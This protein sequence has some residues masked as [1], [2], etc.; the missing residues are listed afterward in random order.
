[1]LP[2]WSWAVEWMLT[3]SQRCTSDHRL[4]YLDLD[5]GV[6]RLPLDSQPTVKTLFSKISKI[7]IKKQQGPSNAI[8]QVD[9]Q[10]LTP[11]VKQE[12]SRRLEQLWN[13]TQSGYVVKKV[14]R[15]QDQLEELKMDVIKHTQN[16]E[17]RSITP[18][19][20]NRQK[21]AGSESR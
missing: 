17:W 8:S 9:N 13:F 4:V 19:E 12:Y 6:G 3:S 16:L 21:K 5:L 20:R 2:H 10:N 7:P 15:I 11:L 18:L 1:M 14:K